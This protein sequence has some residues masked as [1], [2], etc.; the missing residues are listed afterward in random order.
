MLRMPPDLKIRRRTVKYALREYAK[1]LLPPAAARRRKRPFYVPLEKFLHDP[2]FVAMANDTLSDRVVRDR[3][4]FQPRAVAQ[5]RD[6]MRSGGFIE[7]KQVFS[8]VSLELWHRIMIDQR[9][10][11]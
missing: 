5:L 7:A 6:R 4:I 9:G 11:P 2:V 1:K 10:T 8:L 3:G